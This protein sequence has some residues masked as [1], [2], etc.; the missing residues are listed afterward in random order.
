MR[1]GGNDNAKKFFRKHGCTEKSACEKKYTSK[2]AVAYRAELAKAVDAEGA[3]RGESVSV[4]SGGG[5]SSLLDNANATMQKSMEDEARSKLNAA[6]SANGGGG[7]AGVLQPSAKLAS[8]M[9]GAKGRLATPTGTP[10]PTPPVSGNLG[11]KPPTKLNGSSGPKLVLR[12][13]T[14][15]T[16]ASSRLLKK[17]STSSTAS[18]LRVNKITTSS[19][20]DDGF[21]DVETTQKN[22]VNQKLQEENEKKKREKEDAKLARELQEQL[23]G[24]GNGNGVAAA[25]PTSTTIPAATNGMASPPKPVVPAAPPKP[26]I[27]AHEENMKK[28]SS[29]NSDFFS[30]L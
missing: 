2:A 26:Q 30:G 16:S 28:L 4:S 7:E 9:S 29:M 8:Q 3:K 17:T 25:A 18:K 27:S 10:V 5:S 19:G 22:I 24:L 21:E 11:L 15:K 20:G 1:I 12:K 6:R 14:S 23:N 13:P